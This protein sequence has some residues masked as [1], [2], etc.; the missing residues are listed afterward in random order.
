MTFCFLSQDFTLNACQ[1]DAINHMEFLNDISEKKCQKQCDE[2]YDKMCQYY[3]YHR[4]VR[5]C[6]L[7]KGPFENFAKN[8][9]LIGGPITPSIED[10]SQRDTC[11]VRSSKISTFS[12]CSPFLI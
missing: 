8:C 11:N 12:F 5:L 7:Y 1:S 10:C 2:A 4:R 6:T 3:T 9:S